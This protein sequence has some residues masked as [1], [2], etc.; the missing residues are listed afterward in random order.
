MRHNT[1]QI[2]KGTQVG[3][4]IEFDSLRK[5]FNTKSRT[6]TLYVGSVKDN[7][8]HVETAS[9]VAGLL[10]VILMIQKNQIVKQA[11]FTRLNPNIPSLDNELIDIPTQLTEWKSA[12]NSKA[13]AMVTN[14]GAAGSN[15]AIIVKQHER[16]SETP[17]GSPKLPTEIPII[18]TASSEESLRSYCKALASDIRNGHVK[19]SVDLSYN[20]A[21]KQNRDLDYVQAFSVPSEDPTALLLTLESLVQRPSITKK[22]ARSPLPIIM[23]FGGQNGNTAHLSMDLFTRNKLLQYHLVSPITY[24][25]WHYLYEPH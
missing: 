11:N 19:R 24:T 5:T 13:I 20:L 23:C 4:P 2:D 15:A 16:S 17:L 21:I 12:T 10:K 25:I 18:I 8:G 3:D 1:N 7:I 6:D 14:Y 22:K 9:G